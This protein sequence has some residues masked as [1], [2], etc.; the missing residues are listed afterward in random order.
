MHS[1]NH[2]SVVTI[3]NLDRG[4]SAGKFLPALPRTHREALAHTVRLGRSH[5]RVVFTRRQ[6]ACMRR[7]TRAGVEDFWKCSSPASKHRKPGQTSLG[8]TISSRSDRSRQ[9]TGCRRCRALVD[10]VLSAVSL[11]RRSMAPKKFKHS[12]KKAKTGGR[13]TTKPSG[14]AQVAWRLS[15]PPPV[16]WTQRATS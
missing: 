13:S 2:R 9:R 7:Q 5:L 11:K 15:L 16:F 10:S 14:S 6:Y 3:E 12:Y 4:C 1:G 8:R